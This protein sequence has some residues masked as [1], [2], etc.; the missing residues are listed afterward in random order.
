[1]SEVRI[2][3]NR[4]KG[5][6]SI[7][8]LSPRGWKLARH[9]SRVVLRDVRFV[10]SECGRQWVLKNKKRHVHA[11]VFG[12]LITEDTKPDLTDLGGLSVVRYNPYR[13]GYFHNQDLRPVYTADYV[14]IEGDAIWMC[15]EVLTPQ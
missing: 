1:M 3:Y 4:T 13:A 15:Q 7:N 8:E 11:W 5:M 10:V 9:T 12:T 2:H 14:Y 6:L